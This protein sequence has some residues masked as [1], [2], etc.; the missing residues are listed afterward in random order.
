MTYPANALQ[1]AVYDRLTGYSPLTAALGGSKVY[2]FVP[3][4]A[5]PPYVVIGD[6]TDADWSTKTWAGWE[7]TVTIHA[8]DYEAAG[9]KS[10]KTLLGHLYDALHEQEAGLS[11]SGFTLV[12]IR[13]EF[14]QTF[15]ETAADG[16]PDRYYH[17]VMRFRAVI[18][19]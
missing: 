12:Q 14:A 10:V 5:A 18:E 17:G 6:D 4:S 8:W 1:K 3:E 16:A 15:Q 11:V 19:A 13:Y 7:C 2:D 9:R